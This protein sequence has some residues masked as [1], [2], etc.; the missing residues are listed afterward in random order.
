VGDSP[1][2]DPHDDETAIHRADADA[3]AGRASVFE[4]AF[5]SDGVDELVLDIVGNR[6]GRL[7]LYRLA[8]HRAD[9]NE[10]GISVEGDP[11]VLQRWWEL[12]AIRWT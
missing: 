9:A 4:A 2:G 12:V 11:A 8:W 6:H 5:A 10:A 7:D 1:G 3:A